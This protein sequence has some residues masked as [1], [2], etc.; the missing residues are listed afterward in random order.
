[1]ILPTTNGADHHANNA[2]I[3]A[4]SNASM[5]LSTSTSCTS[6]H[7]PAPIETRSAI[8]R[9]RAAA[10][11]VIRLATLAQAISSTSATSTPRA[12]SDTAVLLLQF[13]DARG[14]RLQQQLLVQ[15]SVD[16]LLASCR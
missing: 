16:V 9:A 2:P 4:A 8:S 3:A 5:A 6:R 7:R 15:E 1:M 12:T 13:G 10:C 11:A 14:R